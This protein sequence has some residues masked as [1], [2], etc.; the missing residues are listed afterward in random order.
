[1][2]GTRE[3]FTSWSETNLDLH[4]ELVTNAKCGVEG[5]GIIRF[6]LESGGSLEL[7]NVLWILK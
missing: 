3:L 5:V 7:G 1:M 6:Q 2:T 4:V